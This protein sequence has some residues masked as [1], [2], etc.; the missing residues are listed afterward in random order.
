MKTCPTCEKAVPEDK[1]YCSR[2]CARKGYRKNFLLVPKEVKAK[3]KLDQD[4]NWHGGRGR[5]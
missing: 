5:G 4:L 2:P 1:T 3:R